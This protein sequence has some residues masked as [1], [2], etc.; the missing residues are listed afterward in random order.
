MFLT[1]CV[2]FVDFNVFLF[3]LG[4]WVVVCGVLIWVFDWVV[5]LGLSTTEV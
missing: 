4:F 1:R 3:L 2:L 5:V